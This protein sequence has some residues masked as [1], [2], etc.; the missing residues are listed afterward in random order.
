MVWQRLLHVLWMKCPVGILLACSLKLFLSQSGPTWSL[1]AG[2]PGF[3]VSSLWCQPALNMLCFTV[4]LLCPITGS[5]LRPV[6]LGSRQLRVCWNCSEC[7]F[8]NQMFRLHTK[9]FSLKRSTVDFCIFNN[10]LGWF[11]CRDLGKKHSWSKTALKPSKRKN[12]I[13]KIFWG[14][15]GWGPNETL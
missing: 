2:A 11:F 12:C 15:R 8:K 4:N 3:F 14:D 10:S 7:S 1:F 13:L 6:P 5:L 9:R